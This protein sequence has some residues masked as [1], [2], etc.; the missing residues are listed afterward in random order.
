[1]VA[2][3]LSVFC[4]EGAIRGEKSCCW[5]VSPLDWYMSPGA[6]ALPRFLPAM[7][8]NLLLTFLARSLCA[9]IYGQSGA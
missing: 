8:L 6:K 2:E 7:S 1:M 9:L 4:Q 3:F 5:E